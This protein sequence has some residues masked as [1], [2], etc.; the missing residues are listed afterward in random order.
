[1]TREKIKTRYKAIYVPYDWEETWEKF[2]KIC[3]REGESVSH[4]ILQMLQEYIRKH[5]PGNPQLTLERYSTTKALVMDPCF[6]CERRA[7]E[8]LAEYVRKD[9]L[10][11]RVPLCDK[12]K[13]QVQNVE[14]WTNFEPI[15][16]GEA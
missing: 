1:M 9:G 12:C 6:I 8:W 2:G 3:A 5:E 4:R 10:L 14:P 15:A 11:R 7:V 13:E 16:E